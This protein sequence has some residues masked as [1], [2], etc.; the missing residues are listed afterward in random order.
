MISELNN[1]T[2]NKY[3]EDTFN[4]IDFLEENSL[5]IQKCVASKEKYQQEEDDLEIDETQKSNFQN[6]DNLVY[7]QQLKV[8]IWKS[9]RE[10]QF[11]KSEWEKE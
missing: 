3:N 2:L 5:K 8:D 7:D 1:E 4:A 11:K 10:F 6:L 9:V